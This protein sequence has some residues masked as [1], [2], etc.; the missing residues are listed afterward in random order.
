MTTFRIELIELG[1]KIE[2]C[3]I[4][5]VPLYGN[6]FFSKNLGTSKAKLIDY[7]LDK[8]FNPICMHPYIFLLSANETG[9]MQEDGGIPHYL[10]TITFD[11]MFGMMAEKDL[12]YIDYTK[13]E[14]IDESIFEL[15]L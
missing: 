8:E 10:Y 15:D 7:I 2:N 6:R 11:R 13:K 5:F 4:D 9:S 12:Y 14:E 1:C 3:E